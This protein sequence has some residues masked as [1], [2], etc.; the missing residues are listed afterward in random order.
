[1]KRN[2]IIYGILWILSLVGI[3]FFGGTVSYGIFITLTFLPLVLLIYLLSVYVFFHIFQQIDN[4]NLV[5][6]R[7]VPFYFTLMNEYHFGFCSIKIRFYSSFSDISGLDDDTEYE[8]LPKTGIKKYTQLVCRYRG[9]YEVG[10]KTVE[11]TDFLKLIRIRYKNR[12]PLRV[13][14]KPDLVDLTKIESLDLSQTMY[15]NSLVNPVEPDIEVRKYQTGDDIR[16]INWKASARSG[17]LLVRKMTASER[18]G[19]S[20]L[21]DTKRYSE[22]MAEYLPLENKLL[23]LTIALAYFFVRKNIPVHVFYLDSVLHE[24]D[25]DALDGFDAF[26]ENISAVA[27]QKENDEEKLMAAACDHRGLFNCRSAFMVLHEWNAA[28][29]GT[30]RLLRENNIFTVACIVED[31]SETAVHGEDIPGFKLFSIGTHQDIREAGI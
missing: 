14:V 8:L 26:Y 24:A 29:D 27:F 30:A 7:M 19:V 13:Y 18:E 17:E 10:I 25:V 16:M 2:R 6:G 4:K 1:M 12:E 28:V 3:S 21:M 9:E 20:I 11:I 5:A 23:E 31:N 22:N 15:K